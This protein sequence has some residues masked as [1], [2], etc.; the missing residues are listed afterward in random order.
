MELSG[1]QTVS[2][3]FSVCR[4]ILGEVL[5]PM[6]LVT[7]NSLTPLQLIRSDVHTKKLAHGQKRR[8]L[9]LSAGKI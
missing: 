4:A 1:D 8:W 7:L 5:R 3:L 6:A 2:L 9:K